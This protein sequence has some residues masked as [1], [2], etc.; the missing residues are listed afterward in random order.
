MDVDITLRLIHLDIFLWFGYYTVVEWYSVRVHSAIMDKLNK[1]YLNNAELKGLNRRDR[2]NEWIYNEIYVSNKWKSIAGP[3]ILT[4]DPC[5]TRKML[6]HWAIQANLYP[7]F[8]AKLPHSSPFKCCALEETHNKHTLTMSGLDWF[9]KCLIKDCH[10]P[11]CNRNKRKYRNK[12]FFTQKKKN[13]W[14]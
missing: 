10:S 4:Q 7:W 2:R 11:K 3:G 14:T 13:V 1:T 8:L 5:L 6:Y 9:N 12:Q